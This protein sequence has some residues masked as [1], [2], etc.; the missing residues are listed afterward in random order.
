MA[1]GDRVTLWRAEIIGDAVRQDQSGLHLPPGEASK[2]VE[3]DT[4][5]DFIKTSIAIMLVALFV[6]FIFLVFMMPG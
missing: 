2:S 3:D 5:M 6:W 1:S 4:R